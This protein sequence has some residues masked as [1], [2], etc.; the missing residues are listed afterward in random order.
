VAKKINLSNLTDK[1]LHASQME[2]SLLKNLNHPHIVEYI[3]NFIEDGTFIIIM[4]YCEEGDL[5]FHVSRM[6][7]KGENFSE[8][9]ILNWFLQLAFALSYIHDKKILHRDLKTSNIFLS[10]SGFVKIGDFGISK[11][12][13]GTL[14]N[15]ETIVGTPYYMSPE[16]CENVPYSYKSDVW[17]LGCVVY[18]LCT[19]SHAFAA[20]NLLGLVYKIVQEKQE[21]IPSIYSGDLNHLVQKMLIKNFRNRPSIKDIIGMPWIR[22]TAENFKARRGQMDVHLPIKKTEM[23]RQGGP[24]ENIQNFSDSNI[25]TTSQNASNMLLTPAERAKKKKEDAAEKR[26]L[27]LINAS[28]HSQDFRLGTGSAKQRKEDDMRSTFDRT[29]V[30]YNQQTLNLKTGSYGDKTLGTNAMTSDYDPNLNQKNNSNLQESFGYSHDN[31][32]QSL[33]MNTIESQNYS[34]FNPNP[35]K[36]QKPQQDFQNRNQSYILEYDQTCISQNLPTQQFNPNSLKTNL[37]EKEIMGDTVNSLNYSQTSQTQNYGKTG[38]TILS[39]Y[40]PTQLN[41]F[42][43]NTLN[44]NKN[45]SYVSYDNRACKGSQGYQ[46]PANNNIESEDFEEFND[47]FEEDLGGQEYRITGRDES[48]ILEVMDIY[49]DFLKKGG[50]GV[51]GGGGGG[52]GRGLST[53]G[54]R[55]FEEHDSV[56]SPSGLEG[57]DKVIQSGMAE[58]RKNMR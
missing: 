9:L 56:R 7:K 34:Q 47:D 14:E 52:G 26:R 23:H 30:S 22:K 41:P 33:D 17:A 54:E 31:T 20:N 15:A 40:E 27:E 28:K 53:V 4:E 44:P 46:L 5:A 29:T 6:K 11:I 25:T 19:L 8:D 16:V 1:D 39:Q 51:G 49:E 13:E 32:V 36:P 18:E 24:N 10:S 38:T 57:H 2:A 12:L 45:S 48:E 3:E 50:G 21:P 58:K 43:K 37:N 42:Q 55:S 35:P